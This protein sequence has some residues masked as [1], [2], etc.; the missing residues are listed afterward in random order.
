[1][2]GKVE[3]QKQKLTRD[4]VSQ[5]D[6][7]W[8]IKTEE[9]QIIGPFETS[10][11]LSKIREGTF[12][13]EEY[14]SLYPEINWQ[15]ITQELDFYDELLKSLSDEVAYLDE[16]NLSK[17]S[18]SINQEKKSA[19]NTPSNA[20]PDSSSSII[21]DSDGDLD[22]FEQGNEKPFEGTD[23]PID[24]DDFDDF[25]QK[26]I[27]EKNLPQAD[28]S[29]D[30]TE[31]ISTSDRISDIKNV[32]EQDPPKIKST[33]RKV[34]SD[35]FEENDG[36]TKQN[37][38]SQT[39]SGATQRTSGD[40]TTS[41]SKKTSTN[42]GKAWDGKT[43]SGQSSTS[44]QSNTQSK[45]SRSAH[46]SRATEVIDLKDQEDLN[47]NV[48]KRA[49]RKPL[50]FIIVALLAIVAVLFVPSEKQGGRIHLLKPSA[51][52]KK[53]EV[54]KLKTILARGL[55]AFEK[56][57][58]K[59]YLKAQNG[60]TRALEAD[61]KNHEVWALL[62]LTYLEL[63]PYTYQ[64]TQDKR[65]LSYATQRV[66]KVNLGGVSASTCQTVNLILQGR[67]DESK[68]VTESVLANYGSQGKPPTVFY[69]LKALQLKSERN[70]DV[71][72][73]YARSTQK[74]WPAW[75]RVYALEA[76]LHERTKNYT[77]AAAIYRNILKS[78]TKHNFSKIKLGL[79]ELKHFNHVEL[80]SQLLNEAF[81]SN[82]LPV[83]SVT[84]KGYMGLAEIALRYNNQDEA[85]K[86]A[87]KAY[88]LNPSNTQAKNLIVKLGGEKSLSAL[89][90]DVRE[91]IYEGDQYF[92][93]GDFETA[94]AHYKSAF[95][96]D[97]KSAQAALKAA[98]CMWKLS[99]SEAAIEWLGK[100]IKADA[101]LLDA[102]ITL[103]KY[104][105]DQFNYSIALKI[106][107]KANKVAP[108]SYE[109]LRGFA[110]VELK[111]HSF[112]GAVVYAKKA[113]KLYET[114][115]E[116]YVILA[117]AHLA[118]SAYQYAYTAAAKAIEIDANNQQ[119]Q[120]IYAK[121]LGG[122]QGSD[123]GVNYTQRLVENYPLV[124]E[125]RLTLGEILY[126]DERY[127]EAELVLTQLI[128]IDQKS[129]KGFLLL[130][131][132]K[133]A[134][135]KFEESVDVYFRGAILNPADA[136]PLFEAGLVYFEMKKINK[137]KKQF[138]RVINVNPRYARAHYYLGQ[139][140]L[141]QR[142][143]K[144]SIAQA[145]E[146]L[147]LNP[148]LSEPYLLKA[149]TYL[150][151]KQYSLCAREYQKA[152]K[153]SPQ[154]AQSYIRVAKCYR[155]SGN[156]DVAILMLK[157]AARIESGNPNIYK[158]QGAI[159]ETKGERELAIESYTQY[160]LLAPNAPDRAQ[161]EQRIER[162]GGGR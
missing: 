143:Y 133:K 131:R 134:L 111:R 61:P 47:R 25:N 13:G 65:T 50:I 113:I 64:D 62:C 49:N 97:P 31:V 33:A 81:Q 51:A 123:V 83:G 124:V 74:L 72:V 35:D 119:A 95:E 58:K 125:Y 26:N 122:L 69:Y 24:E 53:L 128:N 71:G 30:K 99:F 103:S 88:I 52:L 161:I 80:A 96:L 142:D 117:K 7:K 39:Q 89:D 145:E 144:E 114:D 85:I 66:S 138:L 90:L 14:I 15:L 20:E 2:D 55:S 75:I 27:F 137:A 17:N 156:L 57:T 162:L 126:D 108:K 141:I 120:A 42:T 87:K 98:K 160:F 9:G 107:Q 148:N 3:F 153:L 105:A 101:K 37:R 18:S 159:F 140:A 5:Q 46:K 151:M 32:S 136:T 86:F 29:S 11:V 91:M 127:D 54:S 76:E 77:Y 12:T 104:Q 93:Q 94:Q 115:V 16:E 44:K 22:G 8:V 121:T 146:E 100:A 110:Y 84:S 118:M 132:T 34:S 10:M 79:L 1:M 154:G 36:N 6:K 130:G 112:S 150:S 28:D 21:S 60:F 135:Q 129:Q 155:L 102:Y 139:I 59:N 38:G 4:S 70:F 48:K 82:D 67:L 78:N 106:L 40:T 157:Q 45:T 109:V 152:I 92:R 56:D 68:T 63:W 73:G 147:K 43:T 41:G 23:S 116:S 158:E 19:D 149:E